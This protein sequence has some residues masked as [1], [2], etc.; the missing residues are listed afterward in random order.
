MYVRSCL[1]QQQQQ[2]LAEM[3]IEAERQVANVSSSSQ[4]GSSLRR[5]NNETSGEQFG[6]RRRFFHRMLIFLNFC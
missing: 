6:M 5:V 3:W 1:K 4:Y 2:L